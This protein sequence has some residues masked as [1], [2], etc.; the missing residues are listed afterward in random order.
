MIVFLPI[1]VERVAEA[2]RGCRLAL[3]R[4]GWADRREDKNVSFAIRAVRETA[5]KIILE[6]WR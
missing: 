6:A 3:A 5:K 2:D 4:R 1:S